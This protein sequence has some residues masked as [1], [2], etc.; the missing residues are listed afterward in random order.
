MTYGTE[1]CEDTNKTKHVLRVAEMKTLRTIVGKT[2]SDIVRNPDIREQR[3][4]QD[5]VRCGRQ[6]KRQWYNHVRRMDR[7]AEDHSGDHLKD[8]EIVRNRPLRK[9]CRG[10]FRINKSTDFQEV[11]E[12]EEEGEEVMV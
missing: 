6:R 5:I 8:E 11:I 2:K 7:P 1:V 9:R 4:I 3:G 10:C 12:E